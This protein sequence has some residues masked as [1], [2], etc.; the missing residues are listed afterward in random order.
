MN[1]G[2]LTLQGVTDSQVSIIL[3]VKERHEG[4][5]IFEPNQMQPQNNPGQPFNSG[6]PWRPG[7][8]PGPGMPGWNP[9][10][11]VPQIPMREETYNN[12]ILQFRDDAGLK[13]VFEV[14]RGLTGDGLPPA[15]PPH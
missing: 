11:P 3:E 6:Q 8:P 5:L 13:A 12:V 14:L 4:V 7:M 1:G 2:T 15:A 10:Q 9:G